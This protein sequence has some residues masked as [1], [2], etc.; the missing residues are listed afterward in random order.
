MA[1]LKLTIALNP[2]DRV[3]ALRSGAVK[4]EGI[5]LEFP[6]IK[7]PYEIFQR[8]AREY[9]F[10]IGEL[11]TTH[12]LRDGREGDAYPYFGLP[13]F[14]SRNFCHKAILVNAKAGIKEPKDLEGKRIGLNIYRS[15]WAVWT[16]GMLASEYGIDFATIDWFEIDRNT[17][18][19]VDPQKHFMVDK[20][21]RV[22]RL[23]NDADLVAMLANDE[24]D[25]VI[26]IRA[27]DRFLAHPYI[28]RLFSNFREVER[29]YYKKTK[30]FPINQIVVMKKAILEREPWAAASLYKAFAE[31]KAFRLDQMRQEGSERFFSPWVLADI[32]EMDD[33]FEGDPWPYGLEPNRVKLE[34]YA[35]YQID[36][37]FLPE[38]PGI[39]ERF[40]KPGPG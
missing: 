37:G 33:M 12:H 16:R 35:Q 14:P 28:V 38:R 4:A 34:A 26:G 27:P 20:G 13:V 25:A 2:Y 8:T 39:D 32:E 24:I 11:G 19:G 40:V 6:E 30:I 29:N 9:A 18:I 5:D 23:A 3:E 15:S 31:A 21:I 10:D 7:N 22:T 17:E 36:Q 1:N